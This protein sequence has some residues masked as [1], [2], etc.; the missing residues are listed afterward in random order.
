MFSCFLVW[1]SICNVCGQTALYIPPDRNAFFIEFGG[2]NAIS[3][4]FDHRLNKYDITGLG[5]RVGAGG[6]VVGENEYIIEGILSLN[7][8]A[9]RNGNYFEVSAGPVFHNGVTQAFTGDGNKGTYVLGNVYMGYRRQPLNSAFVFRV[10]TP[11]NFGVIEEEFCLIPFPQGI[12]FG[13]SF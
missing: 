2:I 3:L 12:S 11:F 5:I 6:I 7:Y 8:L 13:I 10:G 1:R 9:G 4:N